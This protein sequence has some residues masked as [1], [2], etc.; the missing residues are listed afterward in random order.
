VQSDPVLECQDCGIVLRR[1]SP[2]EASKEIDIANNTIVY[3]ASCTQLRENYMEGLC[4]GCF[5]MRN[6]RMG[7]THC[8]TC[9][10]KG[11]SLPDGLEYEPHPRKS[12]PNSLSEE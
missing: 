5:T 8:D 6:I 1:L 4:A 12:G 10:S 7:E 2:G 9:W 11:S 3:C